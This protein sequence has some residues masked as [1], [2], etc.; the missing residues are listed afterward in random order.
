MEVMVVGIMV[1][2]ATVAMAS[3]QD[4][5]PKRPAEDVVGDQGEVCSFLST[6]GAWPS[7]NDTVRFGSKL[8][9]L[10]VQSMN[11]ESNELYHRLQ[12]QWLGTGARLTYQHHN[13]Q[14]VVYGP[15]HPPQG[16]VQACGRLYDAEWGASL[17]RTGMS[18]YNPNQAIDLQVLPLLAGGPLERIGMP[19]E[20]TVRMEDGEDRSYYEYT[21]GNIRLDAGDPPPVNM[22][23]LNAV[24]DPKLEQDVSVLVPR[25]DDEGL[26]NVWQVNINL[27]SD[28]ATA[29]EVWWRD[30]IL[31]MQP[32]AGWEFDAIDPVNDWDLI[33]EPGVDTPL[34]FKYRGERVSGPDAGIDVTVNLTRLATDTIANAEVL[35]VWAE[36]MRTSNNH[37]VLSPGAGLR[38]EPFG[39]YV[40]KS[41]P[42][43]STDWSPFRVHVVNPRGDAY[44]VRE[45]TVV[46]PE[47]RYQFKNLD[48]ADLPEPW[49]MDL[50]EDGR[51]TFT[52]ADDV[53]V[54]AGKSRVMELPLKV[55]KR[56]GMAEQ[57]FEA[58]LV[59][60]YDDDG[61]YLFSLVGDPMGRPGQYRFVLPPRL[62]GDYTVK[63]ADAGADGAPPGQGEYKVQVD[64]A[65]LLDEVQTAR[66]TMGLESWPRVHGE[67]EPVTLALETGDLLGVLRSMDAVAPDS[68]KINV[69]AT[70]MWGY[71][72]GDYLA[73]EQFPLS[74]DVGSRVMGMHFLDVDGVGALDLVVTYQDGHVMALDGDNLPG[75]REWRQDLGGTVSAPPVL[76][77]VTEDVPGKELVVPVSWGGA[78]WLQVVDRAGN[79]LEKIV[80]DGTPSHLVTSSCRYGV[81]FMESRTDQAGGIAG[82]DT[83]GFLD[84][85]PTS[86]NLAYWEP[87]MTSPDRGSLWLDTNP[88]AIA[89]GTFGPF[90]SCGVVQV[91]GQAL[92]SSPRVVLSRLD[93]N[94][95]SD[96]EWRFE[97][98][99]RVRG[100]WVQNVS[101]T[102]MEERNQV[103]LDELLLVTDEHGLEVLSGWV[104]HVRA[105]EV[106]FDDL[107]PEYDWLIGMSWVNHETGYAMSLRGN[108][109]KTEDGGSHWKKEDW[110]AVKAPRTV[111]NFVFGGNGEALIERDDDAV[112]HYANN[113]VHAFR[114][115][116]QNGLAYKGLAY[117]DEA[118]GI[119]A[120][121]DDHGETAVF[122]WPHGSELSANSP[123]LNAIPCDCQ[124]AS[125]SDAALAGVKDGTVYIGTPSVNRQM[126]MD[127]D[128]VSP[129]R[130]G[131]VLA[132]HQATIIVDTP[133]GRQSFEEV[134][135]TGGQFVAGSSRASADLIK[136]KYHYTISGGQVAKHNVSGHALTGVAT[137]NGAPWLVA[138]QGLVELPRSGQYWYEIKPGAGVADGSTVTIE[139]PAPLGGPVRD[140][141]VYLPDG[142]R[143]GIPPEKSHSVEWASGSLVRVSTDATAVPPSIILSGDFGSRTLEPEIDPDC[144]ECLAPIGADAAV[145]LG[146]GVWSDA[147]GLL[148]SVRLASI[149]PM[150][151]LA[152]RTEG[153]PALV[154]GTVI[155]G[156][157]VTGGFTGLTTADVAPS[158]FSPTDVVSFGVAPRSGMDDLVWAESGTDP[159]GGGVGE[160]LSGQG[161]VSE[162]SPVLAFVNSTT[163]IRDCSASWP[164]TDRIGVRTIAANP[165]DSDALYSGTGLGRLGKVGPFACEK[166]WEEAVSDTGSRIVLTMPPPDR[167]WL[168]ARVY[169]VDVIVDIDPFG[170]VTIQLMD[171]S[172]RNDSAQPNA[173]VLYYANLLV[174]DWSNMY[175]P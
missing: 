121:A 172:L 98:E 78:K 105:R 32:P 114:S 1:A 29:G 54:G 168:G 11:G 131:S 79:M 111:E 106:P 62:A 57:V 51:V 28:Q 166:V 59:K 130:D 87:G 109:W 171:Y 26:V 170:P 115:P 120:Y 17:V 150:P 63:V 162:V 49:T 23:F 158:H 140:V 138:E 116:N 13:E 35:S 100:A 52:W 27:T 6:Y 146:S 48:P 83:E 55:D 122:P 12:S 22:T 81:W 96:E 34:R 112:A 89:E 74:L 110:T 14:I 70:D 20:V 73:Q 101:Y 175:G 56:E 167:D 16:P 118:P 139:N 15:E 47:H 31:R 155:G 119:I 134:I 68:V 152:H 147:D 113:E 107:V 99:G 91:V 66:Y 76:L 174:W 164:H 104:D 165:D 21:Y 151:A 45:V 163:G 156:F 9:E 160:I 124:T 61:G 148:P 7:A 42:Y 30:H 36:G 94:D 142:S 40:S 137:G 126:S 65:G 19:Y 85:T 44:D 154:S 103:E 64:A 136:G 173:E 18:H 157:T 25:T 71:L 5:A 153:G 128:D 60:A 108:V 80:L 4:G 117:A 129:Q 132:A 92:D 39:I 3:L 33:A 8:D 67:H 93:A 41:E 123:R 125:G 169:L 46:F 84:E 82:A 90:G 95:L 149:G 53:E 2:G 37:L 102:P 143:V 50:G 72:S 135:S 145:R 58:P 43:T 24:G 10:G 144:L 38:E 69:T 133:E 77:D 141:V 159:A 88:F 127:A 75:T 97:G 161:L 86:T